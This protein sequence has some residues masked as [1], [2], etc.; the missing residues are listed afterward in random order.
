MTKVCNAVAS[1]L[2][3]KIKDWGFFFMVDS[4]IDALRIAYAYRNHKY[5]SKVEHCRSV[6]QFMVTMFNEHAKAMG[7][8]V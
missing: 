2:K 8:D 4:E 5:G 6:G 1:R 3:P 7:I